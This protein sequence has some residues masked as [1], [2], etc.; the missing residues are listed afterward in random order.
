MPTRLPNMR[1]MIIS[2]LLVR[3]ECTQVTQ[4]S[5][6]AGLYVAMSNYWSPDLKDIVENIHVY[7][8]INNPFILLRMTVSTFS[9]C[10]G[11]S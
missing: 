1:H 8:D 6:K 2:L 9:F 3:F 7:A 10:L 4:L 11:I 5:A